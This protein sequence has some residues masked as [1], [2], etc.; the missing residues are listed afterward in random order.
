[1]YVKLS[2]AAL[3]FIGISKPGSLFAQAQPTATGHKPHTKHTSNLNPSLGPCIPLRGLKAVRLD[4]RLTPPQDAHAQSKLVGTIRHCLT[5]QGIEVTMAVPK[6]I[7]R[8]LPC[9]TFN[10]KIEHK[11]GRKQY[12]VIAQIMPPMSQAS[13]SRHRAGNPLWKFGI[14]GGVPNSIDAGVADAYLLYQAKAMADL[15]V[16]H[17]LAANPDKL[18]PDNLWPLDSRNRWVFYPPMS[19]SKEEVLEVGDVKRSNGRKVVQLKHYRLSEPDTT[20]ATDVYSVDNSGIYH[21]TTGNSSFHYHFPIVAFPIHPGKAK[22]SSP[23]AVDGQSEVIVDSTT[24]LSPLVWPGAVAAITPNTRN[25]YYFIV[26]CEATA[27]V[28]GHVVPAPP[29]TYMIAPGIG[30]IMRQAQIP[31]GNKSLEEGGAILAMPNPMKFYVTE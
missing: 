28:D 25:F 31:M 10:I 1:M 15:F 20:L 11:D 5:K 14:S 17:Y 12:T 27:K 21:E 22:S 16:N 23:V 9:L 19:G 24:E 2:V 29:I 8:E 6:R 3:L 18:T 7:D 30:L 13:K 26:H 4:V